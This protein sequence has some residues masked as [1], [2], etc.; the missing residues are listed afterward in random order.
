MD[1]RKVT[2]DF[3]VA[4]QI[5]VDEVAELAALGFQSIICNRPDGEEIGQ[6]DV[7]AVKAA[8]EKVGL[9]FCHVPVL[10]G[11]MTQDD[12]T[13]QAAALADLPGPVLAYCRSG[14]RSI[15]LWAQDQIGSKG[16]DV[17]GVVTAAANAGYN[18]SGLRG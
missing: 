12:V 13:A 5:E 17:D 2:D 11:A 15:I 4:P 10:S 1:I 8:A 14:T 3:S 6:P 18:L 7:A 9:T 16:A